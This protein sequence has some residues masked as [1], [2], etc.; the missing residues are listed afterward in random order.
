[1]VSNNLVNVRLVIHLHGLEANIKMLLLPPGSEL[2]FNGKGG[3]ASLNVKILNYAS[4]YRSSD[5][6]KK[7]YELV[8]SGEITHV[9]I[10]EDAGDIGFRAQCQKTWH[11]IFR[12]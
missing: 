9:D 2:R 3:H 6:N 7:P 8:V 4:D 11:H 5:G 10:G 1:M 12:K